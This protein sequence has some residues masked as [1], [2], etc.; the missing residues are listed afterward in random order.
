VP[1]EIVWSRR[2]AARLR[3]IRAYVAL[4]KPDAA[5]LLAIR[6]VAVVQNLGHYP[7][8]GR[9]GAEPGLRELVVGKTPYIVIYRVRGAR[10]I[11]TTIR[12]GAWKK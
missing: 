7:Y 1:L 11:I 6:I 5:E 3:E 4:D 10:V 2:A 9:V 8:L 12:H